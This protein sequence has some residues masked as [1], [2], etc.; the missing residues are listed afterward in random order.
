MGDLDPAAEIPAGLVERL[1]ANPTPLIVGHVT[2]DADCL[3]SMFALARGIEQASGQPAL[4]ALPEGS[5]SKKLAFWV[6]YADVK[7]A[8]QGFCRT[9][10]SLA[11]CDTAKLS[12]ANLPK[13]LRDELPGGRSIVNIDHHASNTGFGDINYVDDH[14]SSAAELVYRIFKHAGWQLNPTAATLLCLGICAD[15]VGFSLPNTTAPTFDAAADLL[16]HGADMVLVGDRLWRH[17]S[18]E[19]L[20]LRRV[21]YNNTRL[22]STGKIAYSTADFDEI[23]GCGCSAADIDDQVEIPRAL[24]AAKIA[25]LFTEGRKRRVRIN[26]RSKTTAGVL[27]LAQRIGGGGHHQAAGAIMEGTVENAVSKLIPLAE[28]YLDEQGAG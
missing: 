16:R 25:I 11:I 28:A 13:E 3:G 9:A 20:E 8:E 15:T 7:I 12:R 4:C 21:I 14:A 19:E 27:D 6:D 5:L 18:Q 22:S 2:P 17:Q 24:A 1:T 26:L 10:E 23:K